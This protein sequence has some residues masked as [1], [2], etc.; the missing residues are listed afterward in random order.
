MT[1]FTGSA[2]NKVFHTLTVDKLT[3][4]GTAYAMRTDLKNADKL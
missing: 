3:T 2:A 1:Y 4:N